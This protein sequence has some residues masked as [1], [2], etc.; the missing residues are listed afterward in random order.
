MKLSFTASLLLFLSFSCKKDSSKINQD[1]I[2]QK[3]TL[4]YNEN[5]DKTTLTATFYEDKNGGKNL[6]LSSG[7]GV[8][9]NGA[10]LSFS[11]GSYSTSVD[12]K[13][14]SAVF[15]FTDTE[16]KTYSNTVSPAGFVSNENTAYLDNGLSSYWT[17]GGSSVASGEEVKVEFISQVDATKSASFT[18][19]TAS[20]T[21]ITMS[22][23]SLSVLPDGNANAKIYR[24]KTISTGSFTSVGGSIVTSYTGLENVVQV[25]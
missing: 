15:I 23:S 12:G 5:T 4:N 7:S 10:A 2:F 17:F 11:S 24:T 14:T 1:S 20:A 6:E 3:Y 9:V 25:Y 13:L 21:Y 8:T 16:G 18:E 19:K 22:G